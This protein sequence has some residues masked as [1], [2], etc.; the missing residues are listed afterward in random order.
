MATIKMGLRMVM[1]IKERFLTLARYSR[2][3]INPSLFSMVLVVYGLDE[4]IIGRGYGFLEVV[5]IAT[6][7]KFHQ[8]LRGIWGGKLYFEVQLSGLGIH[9]RGHNVEPFRQTFDPLFPIPFKM[10]AHLK[11]IVPI[12]SLD[13]REPAF[14][15]HLG[16]VYQC[17]E[18]AEF[19]H[20]FHAV[21]R[22]YNGRSPFPQ[23]QDL[24]LDYVCINGIETA[25]RFVK[26]NQFGLMQDRHDELYLLRHPLGEFLYFFVPPIPDIQT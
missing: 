18:L 23:T 8:Q 19:L 14:E 7:G 2:L 21:G 16:I 3:M 1:T 25:E 20:G 15:N 4:D 10:Q 24:I 17:D 26:N 13:V 22:E 6:L 5:H 11:D 12:G 9:G